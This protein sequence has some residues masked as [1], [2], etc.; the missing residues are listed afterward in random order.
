[1]SSTET[2]FVF[3]VLF[4]FIYLSIFRLE[5]LATIDFHWLEVEV[6]QKMRPGPPLTS[7]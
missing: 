6:D 5:Y 7:G 2:R 1:M 4:F 3:N